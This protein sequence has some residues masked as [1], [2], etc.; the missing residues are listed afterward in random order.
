MVAQR[1]AATVAREGAVVKVALVVLVGSSV[2]EG[3]AAVPLVEVTVG[4][5]PPGQSPSGVQTRFKQR[6]SEHGGGRHGWV[7]LRRAD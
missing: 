2:E 3:S 7:C 4:Q 5:P 6:H 1:V